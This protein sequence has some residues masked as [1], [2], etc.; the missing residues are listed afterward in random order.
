MRFSNQYPVTPPPSAWKLIKWILT[1]KHSKWPRNVPIFQYPPPPERVSETSTVLYTC[2]NHSTFLLQ[3]GGYNIL[4]DPVWALHCGPL[5]LI[6]PRRVMKPG[7]T[8]EELPKIDLVLLSHNHYD[9]M[10]SR[11]LKKIKKRDDPLFCVP[12][13]NK[14]RLNKWGISKVVEMQWWEGSQ[15]FPDLKISLTPAQHFSK[16]H[17]LDT[18]KTLWGGYIIQNKDLTIYFAGDTGYGT[19]FTEIAKRYSPIHLA[20]LPIGAYLPRHIMKHHHMSPAEAI[21]AHLDLH[22]KQSVGMHFGTF[23]LGD[24]EHCEPLEKSYIA[25]EEKNVQ[26]SFTELINGET[27]KFQI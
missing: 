24:E 5:G 12:L 7:F 26:Y 16:R 23:Q 15:V 25:K 14:K 2:I 22:A 6:G 21:Q 11:S 4:T 3:T 10:E 9:H 20:F 1:G 27:C 19:H 17:L 18:N 8:Y 13:G